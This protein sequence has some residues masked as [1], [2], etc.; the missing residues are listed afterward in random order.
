MQSFAVEGD[1][2]IEEQVVNFLDRPQTAL[3]L[4]QK[5]GLVKH[6]SGETR[7]VEREVFPKLLDRGSCRLP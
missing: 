5:L 6:I 4:R 1:Q 2:G 3:K 7:N